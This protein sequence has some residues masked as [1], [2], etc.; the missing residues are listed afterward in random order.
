M[1]SESVAESG[2]PSLPASTVMPRTMTKRP[3][4]CPEDTALRKSSS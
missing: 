2:P 3:S 4:A 1:E